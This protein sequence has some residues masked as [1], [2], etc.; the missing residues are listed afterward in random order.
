MYMATFRVRLSQVQLKMDQKNKEMAVFN[1]VSDVGDCHVG[2][3]SEDEAEQEEGL[4]GNILR[5]RDIHIY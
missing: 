5:N 2:H 1:L 4:D 3:L